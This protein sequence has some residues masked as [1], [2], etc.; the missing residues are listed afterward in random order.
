MVKD[1]SENPMRVTAPKHNAGVSAPIHQSAQSAPTQHIGVYAASH[2]GP[3]VPASCEANPTAVLDT[4]GGKIEVELFLDQRAA[5]RHRP[6]E[7]WVLQRHPFPPAWSQIA[8]HH[9]KDPNSSMAGTA[10]QWRE[11]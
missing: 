1:A 5:H 11:H 8:C 9:A 10:L 7:I 4:T 3:L 2:S 6:G